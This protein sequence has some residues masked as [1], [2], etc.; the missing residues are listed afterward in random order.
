MTN[1]IKYFGRNASELPM[2]FQFL[3][4][5]IAENVKSKNA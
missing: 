5:V 2:I 4:T 3:N 1:E